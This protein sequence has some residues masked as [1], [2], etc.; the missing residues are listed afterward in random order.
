MTEC[1]MLYREERAKPIVKI[2]VDNYFV[3]D[4]LDAD[5]KAEVYCFGLGNFYWLIKQPSNAIKNYDKAIILNPRC[6]TALINK[7]YVLSKLGEYN[8]DIGCFDRA[9]KIDPNYSVAWFNKGRVL[10]DLGENDEAIECYNKTTE[11]DP[12]FVEGL[13]NK[14]QVLDKLGKH[15]DF[16]NMS[17]DSLL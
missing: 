2:I 16:P 9:I 6:T 8:K 3:P 7:G 13:I 15:N 1:A 14:G 4:H 11:I 5:K 12:D 10:E 17:A